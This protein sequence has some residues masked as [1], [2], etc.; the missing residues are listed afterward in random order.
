MWLKLIEY[1]FL[2]ARQLEVKLMAGKLDPPRRASTAIHT[3]R[4][5]FFTPPLCPG[6]IF[7]EPAGPIDPENS[8]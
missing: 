2:F 7:R 4:T 3:P 5:F 6:L 8:M 1:S